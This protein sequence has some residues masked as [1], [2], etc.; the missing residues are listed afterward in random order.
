MSGCVTV[1]GSAAAD[2]LAK[3]R[4]DAA[5]AAEHVAE[6]HEHEL[7]A[8]ALQAAA[9]DLGE[10]FRG[11]HD[12]RR[13]DR[14]VRRHEH[15]LLDLG[16]DRRRSHDPRAVGVVEH[17]LPGVGLLHQRHVLVRARVKDD[18]RPLAREHLARRARRA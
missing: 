4:D 10:T 18:A 11:A 3:A 9:D 5:G 13:I 16:R 15:E 7:R 8:P 14:L 12:V 1:T 17:R 6:A 2:L